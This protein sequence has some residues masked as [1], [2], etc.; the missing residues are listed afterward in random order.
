M[1]SVKFP[2]LYVSRRLDACVEGPM[3]WGQG[4]LVMPGKKMLTE[5]LGD[6]LFVFVSYSNEK[7]VGAKVQERMFTVV[8]GGPAARSRAEN[9][10]LPL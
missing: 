10:A 2:D 1:T 6:L 3:S 8:K 7:I 9:G 4:A 5:G